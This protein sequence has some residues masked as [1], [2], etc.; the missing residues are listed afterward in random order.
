MLGFPTLDEIHKKHSD[1][2]LHIKSLRNAQRQQLQSLNDSIDKMLSTATDSLDLGFDGDSMSY[3][4][5]M[6]IYV[7]FVDPLKNNNDSRS[8]R[9]GSSS[10]YSVNPYSRDTTSRSSNYS[11]NSGNFDLNQTNV[12]SDSNYSSWTGNKDNDPSLYSPASNS[13]SGVVYHEKNIPRRDN[14]GRNED[15]SYFHKP[16]SRDYEDVD[17][18][19]DEYFDALVSSRYNSITPTLAQTARDRLNILQSYEE[20]DKLQRS[21]KRNTISIDKGGSIFSNASEDIPRSQSS[22]QFYSN[23]NPLISSR[24]G[25]RPPSISSQRS[26]RSFASSNG[27]SP[28]RRNALYS[29]TGDNAINDYS[30]DLDNSDFEP[31]SSYANRAARY[32]SYALSD[33]GFHRSNSKASNHSLS[34]SVSHSSLRSQNSMKSANSIING[35]NHEFPS[36]FSNHRTLDSPKSVFSSPRSPKSPASVDHSNELKPAYSST[37]QNSLSKSP[38]SSS[39]ALLET[40]RNVSPNDARLAMNSP[41]RSQSSQSHSIPFVKQIS[42]SNSF[43]SPTSKSFSSRRESF[44]NA[45]EDIPP[46]A[47]PNRSSVLSSPRKD[48]ETISMIEDTKPDQRYRLSTQ[49]R[50]N[51]DPNLKR[52]SSIPPGFVVVPNSRTSSMSHATNYQ[53]EFRLLQEQRSKQQTVFDRDS[54]HADFMGKQG[55]GVNIDASENPKTRVDKYVESIIESAKEKRDSLE[56]N[57]FG[58]E[59]DI[60]NDL[61]DVSVETLKPGTVVKVDDDMHDDKVEYI[62]GGLQRI[63]L[64][65]KKCEGDGSLSPSVRDGLAGIRKVVLEMESEIRTWRSGEN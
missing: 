47:A 40:L 43:S 16:G 37:R 8:V 50:S 52:V 22:M 33:S 62:L 29:K 2:L 51:S 49:I 27:H 3:N 65:M 64:K 5:S 55:S 31:S 56:T 1:E 13:S 63:K 15:N 26:S 53:T 19:A 58:S 38:K 10:Q 48:V 39:S 36:L 35:S 30:F 42:H 60:S 20:S 32:D 41:A 23:N 17:R 34:S 12:L 14:Y 7:F 4:S 44:K 46:F 24:F 59:L 28:A 6:A 25:S 11:A 54:F 61:N 21:H 45:E 18:Q 57:I 9:S